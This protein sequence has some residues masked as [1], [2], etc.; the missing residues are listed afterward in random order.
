MDKPER[1]QNAAGEQRMCFLLKKGIMFRFP[2]G[3]NRVNG[4]TPAEYPD[5]RPKFNQKKLEDVTR[6][7]KKPQ[8][9]GHFVQTCPAAGRVVE[10]V[11]YPFRT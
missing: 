8:H 6:N 4:V 2:R 7:L 1:F 5:L 11:K 10:Q 9:A 3:T